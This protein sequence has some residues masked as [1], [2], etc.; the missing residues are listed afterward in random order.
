M[1]NSPMCLYYFGTDGRTCFATCF[2][3]PHP[4][5]NLSTLTPA[6]HYS[7]WTRQGV[8]LGRGKAA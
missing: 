5:D 2:L 3:G 6:L 8:A 7:H 4:S 1:V